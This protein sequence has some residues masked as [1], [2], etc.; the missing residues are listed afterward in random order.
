MNEVERR[1]REEVRALRHLLNEIECGTDDIREGLRGCG[2]HSCMVNKPFGMA[3]N[4]GC[5]C[6][7]RN[8]FEVRVLLGRALRKAARMEE[9]N[10]RLRKVLD[11]LVHLNRGVSRGGGAP[12]MV[13]WEDAWQNAEWLVRG[14]QP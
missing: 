11:W 2:D 12:S 8:T 3:T 7:E 6:V 13:E 14:E 9:E 5:R 10:R 4:G 1:L